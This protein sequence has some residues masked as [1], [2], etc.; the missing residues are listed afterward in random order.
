VFLWATAVQGFR[1][2]SEDIELSTLPILVGPAYC[3]VPIGFLA[4]TILMLIDLP[5]VR[6]RQS[7]LFTQEAP[8]AA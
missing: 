1:G 5:R 8:A 7:L 2:L 3:L 6:K 4:L